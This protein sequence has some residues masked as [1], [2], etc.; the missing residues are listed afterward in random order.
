MFPFPCAVDAGSGLAVGC[1]GME[2]KS[3]R[4]ELL[5]LPLG[6]REYV[7][8]KTP[9]GCYRRLLGC[10]LSPSSAGTAK[11]PLR[12][13]GACPPP[14]GPAHPPGFGGP[15]SPCYRVSVGV[16]FHFYFPCKLKLGV[17]GTADLI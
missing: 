12:A 17:C 4:T 2:E 10:G 11:L 14:L 7:P 13:A 3:S 16:Y 8:A 5:G 9:Y 6:G 1:A 15:A